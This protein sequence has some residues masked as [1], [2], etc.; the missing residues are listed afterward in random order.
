MRSVEFPWGFVFVSGISRNLCCNKF[1]LFCFDTSL[2][3]GPVLCGRL[4]SLLCGS[5]ERSCSVFVCLF[6]CLTL[7]SWYWAEWLL[8]AYA[9][10]NVLVCLC[11][12]LGCFVLF[13][14]RRAKVAVIAVTLSSVGV[15]VRVVLK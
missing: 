15:C 12:G 3:F 4:P 10:L 1:V 9:H 11:L 2:G 6:V 7:H 14:C 13:A 5:C 8:C